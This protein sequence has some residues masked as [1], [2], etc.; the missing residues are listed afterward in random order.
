MW[1]NDAR[2]RPMTPRELWDRYCRYL[3]AVDVLGFRL[4]IS[5]MRFP[6]AFPGAMEAR[7]QAAFAEM[8]ALEAGGIANP[9]EKRMVGHYWLRAPERAPSPEI[10]RAIEETVAAIEA[11]ASGVHEG[12]LRP[13]ARARFTQTL[14]VGIGG[15]ALGP[16]FVADALGGPD[17][18]AHPWFL[19][20]TDP[21]GIDRVIAR[22]GD[23]LAE[24]L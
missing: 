5:R 17:D 21:G 1:N 8:Q 24:T 7:M 14:V 9:D 20:N 23:R 16:Q 19:D 10:R 3:C 4:D 2:R 13:A 22:I 12:R 18:P 15:S 11:F 6:D